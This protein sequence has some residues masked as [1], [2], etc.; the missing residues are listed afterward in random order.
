MVAVFCGSDH[1]Q[2]VRVGLVM[3]LFVDVKCPIDP[4]VSS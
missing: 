2:C 3:T 1:L 4:I